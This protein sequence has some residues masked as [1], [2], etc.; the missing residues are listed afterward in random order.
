MC[1]YIHTQHVWRTLWDRVFLKKLR[2]SELVKKF[3]AVYGT[4]SVMTVFAKTRCLSLSWARSIRSTPQ[5]ISL[6]FILIRSS[7][8][9][10]GLQSC[11]FPLGFPTKLLCTV[12]MWINC[13]NYGS[14]SRLKH[15]GTQIPV[16]DFI[17]IVLVDAELR[18]AVMSVLESDLVSIS[19][20][21]PS[22]DKTR[23]ST[24]PCLLRLRSCV[25]AEA[26]QVVQP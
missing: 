8:L 11:L 17:S 21:F 5:L 12:C 1:I 14:V 15:S 22:L 25:Y 4:H 16:A 26:V 2:V 3:P 7:R 6:R 13:I 19:F 20:A 10:L 18:D 23:N 24:G 9:R